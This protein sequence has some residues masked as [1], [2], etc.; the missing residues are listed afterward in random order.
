MIMSKTSIKFP[1][2]PEKR[3]YQRLDLEVPVKLECDG[4]SIDGTT[5]NIS[6]GGMF[7]PNLNTPELTGKPLTVFLQLPEH[8]QMVKLSGR[9]ARVENQA[10]GQAKGVAI[11]FSGL[12]DDNRLEIDSFIKKRLLQ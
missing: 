5:E 1:K 2:D 8:T 12:Y 10:D 4:Q 3:Y 7:L 11:E 9:V 6:C